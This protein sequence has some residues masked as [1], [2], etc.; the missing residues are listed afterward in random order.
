[1]TII[2]TVEYALCPRLWLTANVIF[3]WKIPLLSFAFLTR[4]L[5][6]LLSMRSSESTVMVPENRML[7]L[8]L[9]T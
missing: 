7:L 5:I 4:S 6:E 8:W 9:L 3:F 2:S 1:M